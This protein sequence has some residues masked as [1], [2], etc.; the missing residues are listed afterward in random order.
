MTGPKIS[1]R[2]IAMSSRQSVKIVGSTKGALVEGG[3]LDTPAAGQ[4][5][6]ALLAAHAM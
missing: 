3:A 4:Q 2:T 6:G 1:S 5:P